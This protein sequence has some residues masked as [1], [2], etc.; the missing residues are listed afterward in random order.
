MVTKNKF[1]ISL[2]LS[3]AMILSISTTFASKTPGNIHLF[4]SDEVENGNETFFENKSSVNVKIEKFLP[5]IYDVIVKTP[6]GDGSILG[7]GVIEV[8]SSG[9]LVFNLYHETTFANTENESG[10]YTVIVGDNKLKNFKLETTDVDPD[11]PDDPVD[12]T[13]QDER[14]DRLIDEEGYIPIAN[15]EELWMIWESFP[16]GELF[17]TGT[18][19]EGQYVTSGLTDKYVLVR[20]IDLGYITWN[21]IGSPFYP[22]SGIFDGNDYK[23]M[24]LITSSNG[25]ELYD[26][27]FGYVDG[28]SIRNIVISDPMIDGVDYAGAL[29]GYIKDSHILNVKIIIINDPELA[30]MGSTY[31]G[32]V[33]GYSENSIVEKV[34]NEVTVV[35]A[36]NTGGIVGHNGDESS[37]STSMIIDAVNVGTVNGSSGV[38]G[39]TGSNYGIIRR[40]LNKGDVLGEIS[41]GGIT[42]FSYGGWIVNRYSIEQSANSGNVKGDSLV[43]GIA[44][45]VENEKMKDVYN[46]GTVEGVNYVGGAI[47][48]FTISEAENLYSSALSTG[49][50]GSLVGEV[51]VYGSI[52][53]GYYN[54]DLHDGLFGEGVGLNNE[55]M[56]GSSNFTDFDF[57]DIWDIIPGE[58]YPYLK[59]HEDLYV[60]L[61]I[62]LP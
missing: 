59:W 61:K 21:M 39:I 32:G 60:P 62:E 46:T 18:K 55:E 31:V 44:G 11:D 12:P 29:A 37:E 53:N 16:E 49:N 45:F 1:I 48:L 43:G 28:A 38:G 40:A 42:G 36:I 58:S 34:Y 50:V 35:G 54:L 19:W 13:P 4:S 25:Y 57:G 3:I 51:S 10:V 15:R 56:T 41:V 30:I 8:G 47:G 17:G 14:A 33:I 2:V 9:S 22:F 52:I 6:G 23:I 26:G 7:S 24:N 20:D 5:G 27:L